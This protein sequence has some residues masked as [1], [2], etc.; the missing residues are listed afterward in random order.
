LYIIIVAKGEENMKLT[1]ALL[2]IGLFFMISAQTPIFNSPVNIYAGA[3]PID[4]GYYGS[5]FYYDWDGDGTKDLIVG[6]YSS[7]KVRFYKN[8]GTDTNPVFGSF[9]YLQADG[10]DISVY[11]A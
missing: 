3:S 6:Q 7:G 1:S 9:S 2:I 11:A 8:T 10:V 4:V 5:P